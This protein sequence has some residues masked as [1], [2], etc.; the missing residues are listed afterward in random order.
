MAI[1]LKIAI[2]KIPLWYR[3]IAIIAFGIMGGVIIPWRT[4]CS[5][6][7]PEH[8]HSNGTFRTQPPEWWGE[9]GRHEPENIR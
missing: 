5:V 3:Q 2:S 6:F 4:A 7:F 1:R 9:R 8:Y